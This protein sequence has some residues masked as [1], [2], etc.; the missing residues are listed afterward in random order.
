MGDHGSS[1]SCLCWFSSFFRFQSVSVKLSNPTF[2]IVYSQNYICLLLIFNSN[3]CYYYNGNSSILPR[4]SKKLAISILFLICNKL[5][6]VFS[7]ILEIRY[8]VVLSY[9]YCFVFTHVWL[10][11]YIQSDTIQFS[12]WLDFWRHHNVNV[13]QMHSRELCIP[14]SVSIDFAFNEYYHKSEFRRNIRYFSF[15][16]TNIFLII[17][18]INIIYENADL[19]VR[20]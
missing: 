4:C 10:S 17:L 20:F 12:T 14:V 7:A 6:P 1:V 2:L 9:S 15:I 13:T 8:Y 16:I 3:I 19:H 11:L 18:K 5:V